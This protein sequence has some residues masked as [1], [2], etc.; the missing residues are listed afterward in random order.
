MGGTRKG[1]GAYLSF[2]LRGR[3]V[4]WRWA[5][6]RGWALITFFCLQ[7]GR[8][9]VVGANSR[10]GAYSNK[11][12][13]STAWYSKNNTCTFVKVTFKLKSRVTRAVVSCSIFHTVVRT[14]SVTLF[15][16]I[17]SCAVEFSYELVSLKYADF[18]LG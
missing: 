5:F 9:F 16:G 10:L 18:F 4:G 17:D 11:Y 8:L 2:S 3:E 6:I 7:D 13:I 1:V 12:G 15:A 14:S